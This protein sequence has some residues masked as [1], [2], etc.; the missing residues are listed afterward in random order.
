MHAPDNHETAMS[1]AAVS[2]KPENDKFAG[3][4]HEG[5]AQGQIVA[6]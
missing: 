6:K 2:V 4:H 1:Q 5:T 3:E